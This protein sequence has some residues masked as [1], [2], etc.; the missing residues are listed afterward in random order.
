M[1]P[2]RLTAAARFFF[3]TAA[4]GER[5]MELIATT[6]RRVMTEREFEAFGDIMPL[7]MQ[8]AELNSQT[9][10]VKFEESPLTLSSIMRICKYLE[11]K[12][13]RI[14]KVIENGFTKAHL[15][16]DINVIPGVRKHRK[17]EIQFKDV[18]SFLFAFSFLQNET[19][20]NFKLLQARITAVALQ[21][22]ADKLQRQLAVSRRQTEHERAQRLQLT[23]QINVGRIS[24]ASLICKHF[25][26][27][28]KECGPRKAICKT[29]HARGW[30]RIDVSE[31]GG[32]YRFNSQE[33]VVN[34]RAF[35]SN[36]RD[37]QTTLARY[38]N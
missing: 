16:A 25:K 8:I 5:T 7:V 13:S 28:Y 15:L 37:R 23:E 31:T 33:C 6:V 24:V 32:C 36:Y 38:F 12:R 30:I 9:S 3:S 17:C 14:C 11:N 35:L 4:V 34:A 20:T 18:S 10:L 22:L 29:W 21:S 27:N 19:A 26:K 2:S 1:K